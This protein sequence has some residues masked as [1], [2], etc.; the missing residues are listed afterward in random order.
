[1]GFIQM[2]QVVKDPV[3]NALFHEGFGRLRAQIPRVMLAINH[4]DGGRMRI[5]YREKI[6]VVIRVNIATERNLVKVVR[7]L[8]QLCLPLGRRQCRQ[9]QRG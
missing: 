4:V 3:L 6:I 1:M 8:R 2:A 5:V 7:S 9:K